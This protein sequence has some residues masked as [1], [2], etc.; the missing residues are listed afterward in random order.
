MIRDTALP[1][2]TP[3]TGEDVEQLTGVR[4]PEEMTR[5][6]WRALDEFTLTGRITLHTGLVLVP[7]KEDPACR[8]ALDVFKWLATLQGKPKK[9]ARAMDDWRPKVTQG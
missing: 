1:V 2:T 9:V 6:A 3:P 5:A 4:T 7:D 8:L